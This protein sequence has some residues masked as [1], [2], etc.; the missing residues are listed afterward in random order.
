MPE[1]DETQRQRLVQEI[2]SARES[3]APVAARFADALWSSGE[4]ALS[5]AECLAMLPSFVNAEVR[6][7]N[8]LALYSTVKH[9]LDGCDSCSADYIELLQLTLADLDN[10][11]LPTSP[12]PTFDL[13]FLPPVRETA[14]RPVDQ[15]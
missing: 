1:L 3:L 13:S 5:H 7:E 11:L 10:Q 2:R 4:D 9:H 14:R 8:V 12:P 6:G 15:P